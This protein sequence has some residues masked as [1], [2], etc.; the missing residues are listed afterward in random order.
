MH[1]G[2]CGV[3]DLRHSL[4]LRQGLDQGPESGLEVFN[5]VR[6]ENHLGL[7]FWMGDPSENVRRESSQSETKPTVVYYSGES[8]G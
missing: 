2:V 1:L 7:L 5:D 3:Q 8:E 4:S 6:P